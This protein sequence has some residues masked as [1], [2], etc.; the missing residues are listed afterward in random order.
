MI[1]KSSSDVCEVNLDERIMKV[2]GSINDLIGYLWIKKGM[3]LTKVPLYTEN[4]F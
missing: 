3:V 4:N 2:G 1:S